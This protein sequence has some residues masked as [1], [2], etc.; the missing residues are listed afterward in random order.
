MSKRSKR[1]HIASPRVWPTWLV[2][3]IGWLVGRLPL[4]VMFPLG[5]YLGRLVFYVGGS[6]RHITETNLRACFPERSDEQ[7]RALSKAVFEAVAIGGLEM[8][9]TWL[10]PKRSLRGRIS[11]HGVEHLQQAVAQGRGVIVLGGHFAT[12]D[13]IAQTLGDLE[14]V[15][16]M[17]RE[18][19]NPVWEWLQVYGRSHHFQGVVEREDTRATLRMLKA[20]RAIWYAAD[21][22]YGAKHSVFAPFFGVETATITATSRFARFNN[23]PVL[24]MTQ[25][26][27]YAARRWSITFGPPLENFPT[28][29][30]RADATRTNQIVEAEVRKHPEQYLWLHKRFK[31][32]PAGEAPFYR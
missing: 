16:V 25:H 8:C 9:I 2:V 11:V 24:M 32:R 3:G 21:Q 15:D 5:K 4:G 30:D 23:S 17:Y 22:D 26:R 14:C 6:R 31:T 19:K 13:A 12:M 10:N 20:G 29:D 28:G 7:I 18:N 1:H 27:D